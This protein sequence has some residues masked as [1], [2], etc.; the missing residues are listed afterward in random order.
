ME[1]NFSLGLG[2]TV[3]VFYLIQKFIFYIYNVD[4]LWSDSVNA[5][6]LW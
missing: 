5:L 2:A 3:I 4:V 1:G 6:L